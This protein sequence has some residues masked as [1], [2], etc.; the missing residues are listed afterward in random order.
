MPSHPLPSRSLYGLIAIVAA[1]SFLPG[2]FVSKEEIDA[3]LDADGDNVP[4]GE[5]CAP[6]DGAY[7]Q[8]VDWYADVDG[9]GFGAGELI[10]GCESDRPTTNTSDNA[11]DCDDSNPSA[12]PGAEERYYDGVDQDCAGE[13]ADGNGSN[14]D[15]DQDGDGWEQDQ[16]CDDTD[17]NLA[18][19]PSLTEVP[20]DGI[21]NDCDLTTG[22]GD[23]DGDGYWSVDYYT[24][25]VGSELSP[26][27]GF[28]GDCF[29]DFDSPEQEVSPHN[30]IPTPDPESVYPG[31]PTDVPYD[32]IDSDC[33]GNEREFDAD[34]DGFASA[35]YPDRSG[36]AGTD[37]QDCTGPCTGEPDWTDL[38]DSDEI[39]RNA[40]ETWYDGVDQ[41]CRGVDYDSDGVEDDF[42]I[43]HDG[44]VAAGYTD[45]F[46][47]VGDDCLDELP[48]ANPG[49]TDT[50]YDGIDLDCGGNDDFDADGDSF[51]PDRYYGAATL[52]LPPD[53]PLLLPGDCVDDP[54][55]DG[56]TSVSGQDAADYNPDALDTWYDGY[57]HDCAGNDDFDQDADGHRTDTLPTSTNFATRQQLAVI[58]PAGAADEDD[59]D[60]NDA[61]ISPSLPE[62]DGNTVDDNCDGTSAPA[63][64]EGTTLASD[65]HSGRILAKSYSNFST[66]IATGDLNNDGTADI[67]VGNSN[68][69]TVA[70]YA[71]AGMWFDGTD[72]YDQDRTDSEFAGVVYGSTGSSFLG[73]SV[74]AGDIDGDS[75]DDFFVG[76]YN[77]TNSGSSADGAVYVFSGPAGGSTASPD[78]LDVDLDAYATI[79]GNDQGILG[80]SVGS[81]DVTGDGVADLLVGEPYY[82]ATGLSRSGRILAFDLTS[83]SG[84][85]SSRDAI[86][87]Y[88]PE[89]NENL[90]MG[91]YFRSGDFN[92]DGSP[93]LSSH[94]EFSST[95]Q[96]GAGASYVIETPFVDGD[97]VYD[98]SIAVVAPALTGDNCGQSADLGDINKDGYDDLAVGC[99]GA[100]GVGVVAIFSGDASWSGEEWKY[101]EANV[102]I[103]GDSSNPYS[104]MGTSV[105]LHDLNN[106]GYADVVAGDRYFYSS[107]TLSFAGRVVF[108]DGSTLAGGSLT[109]EDADGVIYGDVASQQLGTSLAAVPDMD[110]DGDDE[111]LVGAVGSNVLGYQGQVHLFTGGSW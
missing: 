17:P 14:D 108:F 5:D 7:S 96:S 80:V 70:S 45:R 89:D 28:D 32:G 84:V 58:V 41:D 40:D 34:G 109:G 54:S 47:T 53:T 9:D 105:L 44:Y 77:A 76:A 20:Y 15:Y 81:A 90:G 13:D 64:V 42:D 104:Y 4:L 74:G 65:H 88:G 72:L 19:D 56:S 6:N 35:A 71:G 92:G 82:A 48:A 1:S 43:D 8:I 37:C 31:A 33:A 10:S 23:K 59:C 39:Y 3:A 52:G 101:D 107:S 100:F 95:Y 68:D 79:I 111:L 73:Y 49:A 51:V 67:I 97:S 18:P 103:W 91:Q 46:G 75:I 86:S 30:G 66:A 38:I 2:C 55:L 93:D 25:A 27:V 87:I 102:L 36:A 85:L 61:T 60:D 110:A 57:D 16:D 24:K 29:D 26:P 50:W 98:A 99:D 62:T 78:T 12:F 94:N 69:S 22:D 11:D 63:G 21:D 83:D 106:D